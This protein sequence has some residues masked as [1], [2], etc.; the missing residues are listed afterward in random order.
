MSSQQP[1][2]ARSSRVR[3]SVPSPSGPSPSGPSPSGPS[4]SGPSPSG[5]S[6][7]GSSPSGSSPSDA[8]PPGTHPAGALPDWLALI[9]E[10]PAAASYAERLNPLKTALAEAEAGLRRAFEAGGGAPELMPARAALYDALIGALLQHAAERLYPAP[11]P[12]KGE[13]LAAAAVGGYGR[14]EL[15]PHS[16]IDL[17]FLLPYKTT[18]RGEQV[19]EYVLHTLW[20]L[21]LKVGHATRTPADCVR[22]ARADTTIATSLLESRLLWGEASLFAQMEHGFWEKAL[23]GNAMAYVEAKLAE[24]DERHQRLGDSRYVLEPNVK[25]GKGGL[26]DLHTL[27]WIA[28]ALYRVRSLAE[29]ADR[30][31]FSAAEAARFRKAEKFLSDV[32]CH[33]HYA[34]GRGEERLTFDHQMQ[35]AERMHYADRRGLRGVERFMKHFYLV[36]KDVGDLTRI[37]CAALE[38]EHRR[39]ARFSLTRLWSGKRGLGKFEVDHGRINLTSESTF[40]DDPLQLLRI[41][42]QAQEHG[43]DIHPLALRLIRRDLRRIDELRET[44]EAAALF[45]EMLTSPRDPETT[46]RRLSEAGLLGRFLP[47]F[48]RV[49]A[50]MQYDMYHTYTVDEHTI[51]AIGVLRQIEDGAIADETPV[52]SKVVRCIPHRRALYVATL[53]HDIG[54]GRG[55]DHSRIGAR[56]VEEWGPRLGLTPAE[57]ETATW[58]VRQHL[59]FSNYAHRRDPGDPQTIQDFCEIVQSPDRLRQLL[60]L[61]VADIRAVGPGAWTSWKAAL[62][63]EL[64]W[65]AEERL[66]GGADTDSLAARAQRAKQAVAQALAGDSVLDATALGAAAPGAPPGHASG[67]AASGSRGSAH[68]SGPATSKYPSSPAAFG[69]ASGPRRLWTR[70]RARCLWARCLWARRLWARRLWARRSCGCR[71]VGRGDRQP[72][73]SGAGQLLGRLGYADA[74]AACG[75]P[76]PGARRQ[77]AARHRVPCERRRRDDGGHCLLPGPSRPIRPPDRRARPRR[78]QHRLGARLHPA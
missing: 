52:A 56:L 58:L 63:R 67:P 65:R 70:V 31:V 23:N 24:R 35:L 26:R 57:A 50:L 55:G 76:P 16:D 78:R 71:L 7:S 38:A 74:G 18:P 61:T 75:T 2:S 59:V 66:S 53:F 32:R 15:A 1:T 22:F 48:G 40:R 6:P 41:F 37:F 72:S 51:R 9:A 36:A 42:H 3:A 47:P 60:V 34:A 19:V 28:K 62:L 44:P 21:G 12:T 73:S 45:L 29:L 11:N 25:D 69:H 43:L 13:L 68:A 77:T 39:P 8:S 10:P 27:Y 49:V 4:P 20:D 54:K 64:Y 17:L 14:G 30:R 5:P 46:L 33:L